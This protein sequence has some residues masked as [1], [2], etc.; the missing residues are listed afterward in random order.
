[1]LGAESEAARLLNTAVS[2][3]LYAVGYTYFAAMLA[4]IHGQL[5]KDLPRPFDRG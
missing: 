4:A 3:L 1:L 2:A 5:T